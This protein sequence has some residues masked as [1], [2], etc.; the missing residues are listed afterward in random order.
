MNRFSEDYLL[1]LSPWKL[2]IIAAMYLLFIMC[3]ITVLKFWC[4]LSHLIAI[5]PCELGTILI[6]FSLLLQTWVLEMLTNTV[7]N[8][9]LGFCSCYASVSLCVKSGAWTKWSLSNL[10]HCRNWS[11]LGDHLPAFVHLLLLRCSGFLSADPFFEYFFGI[12]KFFIC[13]YNS[14]PS[15]SWYNNINNIILSLSSEERRVKLHT[16]FLVL[17]ELDFRNTES[18]KFGSGN[19]PWMLLL[20]TSNDIRHS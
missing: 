9:E 11:Y 15:G 19:G 4:I 8:I 7:R 17:K 1:P 10:I 16:H 5:T 13:F 2:V 14:T 20:L 3:Q 6:F 18:L 12:H